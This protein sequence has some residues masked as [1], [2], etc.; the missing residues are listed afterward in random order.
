[1][2]GGFVTLF[3]GRRIAVRMHWTAPLG[4]FIFGRFRFAPGFWLGFLTLILVHELGHAVAIRASGARVRSVDLH[5]GGGECSWDGEVTRVQRALI[6]WGGVFAQLVLFGA[7]A[8]LL[9]I[10]EPNLG[11]F[12]GEFAE[13]FGMYNLILAAFNLL[14][15]RGFDGIEA[16]PLFPLLWRGWKRRGAE[17]RARAR[18]D[19]RMRAAAELSKRRDHED[20]KADD[21]VDE[22]VVKLLEKTTG[23]TTGKKGR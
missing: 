10:T 16:W 8:A 6:A 21:D 15:V 19:A 20:E 17:R 14:P 2:S 7:V 9:A 3:R 22:V 5:G 11:E 1:M 23:K 4:A 18:M 13:A 12:A